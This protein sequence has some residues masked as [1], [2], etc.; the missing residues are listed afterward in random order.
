VAETGFLPTETQPW[1]QGIAWHL[2]AAH[3]IH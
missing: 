2:S 3:Q 1:Q